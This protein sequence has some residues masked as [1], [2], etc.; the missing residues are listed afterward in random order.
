MVNGADIA[1]FVRA[2]LGLPPEGGE[3][4]A[5]ADNGGSVDEDIAAFIDI[6]LN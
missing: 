4:Q 2:K 3:N 1:G 6:L 5:C